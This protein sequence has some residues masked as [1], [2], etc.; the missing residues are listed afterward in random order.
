MQELKVA[1]I[2]RFYVEKTAVMKLLPPMFGGPSYG[3]APRLI[4]AEFHQVCQSQNLVEGLSQGKIWCSF[5]M[6]NQVIF[7]DRSSK[8]CMEVCSRRT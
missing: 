4:Q 1:T 2:A 5:A 6:G 8:A 3:S 7:D